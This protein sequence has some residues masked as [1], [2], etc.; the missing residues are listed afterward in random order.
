MEVV[1]DDYRQ[2]VLANATVT[3]SG[4]SGVFEDVGAKEVVLIVNVTGTVSGT[5]PTITFTIQEVDPGN[6]T[7]AISSSA[8]GT[9]ITAV[10]TQ[11]ISLAMARGSCFQITWTVTGT[12]P[13]FGGVYATLV[14]KVAGTTGIFDNAGNGPVAVKPSGVA[15]LATDDALVVTISPNSNANI[16]EIDQQASSSYP[17]PGSYISGNGTPTID[18]YGN[19][20]TRGPVITDE[21]SFRDDFTG[22]ALTTTLTGTVTFTNGST[23]VTGS[24]TSFTTQI[25]MG[26]YVKKSADSETLYAQVSYVVSA[27]QLILDTNYTGTTGG[28][29][30]V[31]S[32]WK[33]TTPSAGSITVAS[34]IVSIATGTTSGSSGSIV[35]L[36]DYLPFNIQF[37]ASL[38]QR[39][40]NQSAYLGLVDN[41][42]SINQQAVI[43]FSGT[44]NTQ[45]TFTTAYTSA[46]T[47][48][49][50]TTVTLPN[51]GTTATYHTYN[52]GLSANQATL[53]IDGIVVA[54]NTI[55]LPTPYTPLFIIADIGNTGTA[56]SSTTLSVDYAFFEDID[57]LQIDQDFNGEPI[58]V[59]GSTPVANTPLTN[60]VPVSGID[61]AGLVR[62]LGS[63]VDRTAMT[64]GA[65]TG[66]PI[67]GQSSGVGRVARANRLGHLTPGYQTLVGFDP[68]EGSNINTWVWTQSTGTMT[69]GQSGGLLTL[70]SGA[71]TTT[72]TYAIITSNS[73]FALFNQ[74]PTGCSFKALVTQ[75]TNSVSELGFGA[76]S[77]T[78]AVVSN[79]AFF[80]FN[81]SGTIF[82]VTSNN[83]TE[84]VSSSLGT[85][86]GTTYYLF[87]VWVEDG[88]A[89]FII[90]SETGV[91]LVD[92]FAPI[93]LATPNVAAA[94]SHLP[95]FARVYTTGTA[96]A[97]PETKITGFQSWRYDIDESKPWAHQLAGTGRSAGI[98]PTT[99][100]QTSQVFTTAPSSAAPTTTG[101]NY[102][103]LG[104]DFDIATTSGSESL[105][106]V[107]GYQVP[108]PY[109]LYV[110]EIYMPQPFVTTVLGA[111]INIE[112]WSFMVANS[113]NP[114]TAT[115]QRYV[116]GIFTAP[117]SSAVGTIF[118]GSPITQ[119]LTAPIVVQPGKYFLILVKHL[120]GPTTGVVRGTIFI[121][122]Y[123][124]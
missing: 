28:A 93:T 78:T 96:S 3:A 107:F 109:T 121:N 75:G 42:T 25:K 86:V 85:L 62:N 60:P 33:T 41:P 110:T 82:A 104:G 44:N 124:E 103:Y 111:T 94:V 61:S 11:I 105:Y 14:N 106:G 102:A 95:A 80:R 112:E 54:I 91:P 2:V 31:V 73:Q 46:V 79:G 37:Y 99:F 117:A 39:I 21:G 74:A 119:T 63:V 114:S 18:A 15:P 98:D 76:P 88:G 108:S 84:T 38:S 32:N 53:S 47:D 87:F 118:T 68:V 23:T 123:F 35:S 4:S 51:G 43:G 122:G 90:E 29:T 72:T 16:T 7:T 13:S 92:Y 5:T 40:A 101:V 49:Q 89:R 8:V 24:G 27:T 45:V 30:S 67:I 55:H 115:G 12:T 1:I 83:G 66:V 57:R 48:T 59:Q 113:N 10:G 65:Q 50:S 64:A 58:P 120:Y 100:L 71:I 70:N 22:T 69:I 52:I 20:E 116:L 56:A 36:S 97:A 77:G 17:D 9:A 6:F 26:Q 81:S 19:L 34:S